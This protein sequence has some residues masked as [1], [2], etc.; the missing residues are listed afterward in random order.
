KLHRLRVNRVLIF[1]SGMI[2]AAVSVGKRHV[3]LNDFKVAAGDTVARGE[4]LMIEIVDHVHGATDRN[5]ARS[6][7]IVTWQAVIRRAALRSQN[8]HPIPQVD[9]GEVDGHTALSSGSKNKLNTN[10]IAIEVRA[11]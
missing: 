5:A 7:R 2:D 3:E 6:A 4:K 1:R 11:R 9:H 8:L 10:C